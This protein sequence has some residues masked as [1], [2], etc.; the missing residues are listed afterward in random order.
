MVIGMVFLCLHCLHCLPGYG[1]GAA[2]L[3]A[4]V[5][6]DG[7][8]ALC[9]LLVGGVVLMDGLGGNAAHMGWFVDVIHWVA[10]HDGVWVDMSLDWVVRYAD[11]PVGFIMESPLADA[12]VRIGS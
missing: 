10:C 9:G 3:L 7:I 2:G 1:S 5:G 8:V 11:Y 6:I 4:R 12:V